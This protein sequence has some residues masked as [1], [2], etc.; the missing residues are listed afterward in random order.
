MNI[1]VHI[2]HPA[3]F[4]LFKNVYFQLIKRHRVFVTVNDNR[5]LIYFLENLQIPHILVGKKQDTILGKA[6]SVAKQD[7]KILRL[8]L[9]NKIQIGLS[10]GIVLSHVSTF[11]K[12]KSFVFDDDDDDVEPLFVKYGHPF[13]DAVL[14]PSAIKKRRV[15][16]AIY[17]SG[18]HELAYLHPNQFQPDTSVLNEVGLKQGD[19]FFIMRF[20]VFKAHHD[21]GING[22]TLEQKLILINLLKPHGKVFITTEREIE[23]ELKPYQMKVSPENAHSLMSFATLFLGDSQTMTSEAAV[24]G[25]PAIKCNSFAGRLSVPNQLEKYGLC[26]S[27]LPEKFDEMVLKVKSLLHKPNLKAEWQIKKEKM[28][29]DKIDVTAFMV[30]FIENYPESETIIK[31]NYD[32]QDRFK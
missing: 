21:I 4:Y 26:F 11:T 7:F 15:K 31:Q 30:W 14:T 8:V 3:H 5:T 17:Y 2:S 28:L 24:L 1:L 6:W 27:F 22:L 23:P 18:Y 20:N 12:M 32:Y 25:T 9:K 16:K 10:S 19:P 29:E 13:S